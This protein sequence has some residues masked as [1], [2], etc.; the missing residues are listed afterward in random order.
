MTL[1]EHIIKIDFYIELAVATFIL[2]LFVKGKKCFEWR[3]PLALV[4]GLFLAL[5]EVHFFHLPEVMMLGKLWQ[6]LICVTF[7]IIQMAFLTIV[8]K[9]LGKMSW[10]LS[11]YLTFAAYLAEHTSS[12]NGIL[13]HVLLMHANN[14]L[15]WN[16][17]N[18][19][20]MVTG[21][22]YFVF[23]GIDVLIL[24]KAKENDPHFE[25]KIHQILPMLA[26]L[27]TCGLLLNLATKMCLVS[28][29]IGENLVF[30]LAQIGLIYDLFCSLFMIWVLV[31]TM[32]NQY[33]T[34][35]VNFEQQLRA[36]QQQHFISSKKN[37]EMINKKCHQ[38]KH[39]IQEVRENQSNKELLEETLLQ[40]EKD[41]MIYNA[42][43]KTGNEIVDVAVNEKSLLCEQEGITL[44]C[45]L[46]GRPFY[47]MDS[48]N[49]Y[50]LFSTLLDIALE[51]TKTNL[52]KEHKLIALTQSRQGA[53]YIIQIEGFLENT[54]DEMDKFQKQMGEKIRN[55][56]EIAQRYSGEIRLKRRNDIWMLNV[57][58]S[59]P[60][61]ENTF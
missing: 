50:Q 58:V 47:A 9:Y 54:D 45:L 28:F 6:Y 1:V 61:I 4:A 34:T 23:L 12:A 22:A 39:Q 55:I 20:Q 38:L 11:I 8:G 57:M 19:Y 59:L 2:W 26:S 32:N 25:L 7:F 46:D 13:F 36:L 15:V 48:M 14:V 30:Y 53:I 56:E 35:K 17:N 16:A 51:K 21:T 33:L 52:I 44:T 5:I 49:V 43:V 41:I 37:I 18:V 27:V 10:N 29:E 60:E 42:I 31:A 24:Y 3:Y 40:L